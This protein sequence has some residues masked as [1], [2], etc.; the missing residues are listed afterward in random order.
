MKEAKFV[1]L[2]RSA[3]VSIGARQNIVQ[4]QFVL[5]SRQPLRP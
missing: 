2:T 3:Y 4:E 5:L 1:A